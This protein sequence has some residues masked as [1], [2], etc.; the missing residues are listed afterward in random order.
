MQSLLI[1]FFSV[2]NR[3]EG[4]VFPSRCFGTKCWYCRL[5]GRDFSGAASCWWDLRM[6][7][8]LREAKGRI[9]SLLFV[10]PVLRSGSSQLLRL[11]ACGATNCT[12]PGHGRKL[13]VACLDLLLLT[14]GNISSSC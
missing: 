2:R 11:Q 12:A 8:P 10:F 7:S 14:W 9:L 3:A 13:F 5:R 1:P 6:E 4:L